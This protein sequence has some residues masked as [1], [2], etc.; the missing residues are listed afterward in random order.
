MYPFR[1]KDNFYDEELLAPLLT[2]KLE[3]YTMMSVHDCL[4]K[5]IAPSFHI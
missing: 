3:D 2:P 4:F 1:N 5:I